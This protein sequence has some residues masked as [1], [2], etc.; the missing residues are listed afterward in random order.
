MSNNTSE[1]RIY[2]K[3]AKE[4]NKELLSFVNSTNSLK[5]I[6]ELRNKKI[7]IDSFVCRNEKCKYKG[8]KQMEFKERP[9]VEEG[10][11]FRCGSCTSWRTCRTDSFLALIYNWAMLHPQN[12]QIEIRGISKQTIV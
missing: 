9:G 4:E 3:L 7:F 10:H 6:E 1:N 2:K 11:W 5:Q 8:V 12:T